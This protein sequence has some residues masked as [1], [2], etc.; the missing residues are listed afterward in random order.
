[1]ADWREQLR[2]ALGLS[3]QESPEEV[4]V[5]VRGQVVTAPRMGSVAEL[6]QELG[7]DSKEFLALNLDTAEV[8]GEDEPVPSRVGIVP[9]RV[10]G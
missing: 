9:L 10:D 5:V 3:G 6:F 4:E 8:L 2:N 7:L 1:M